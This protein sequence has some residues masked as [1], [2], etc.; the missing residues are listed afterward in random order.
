[1]TLATV[2]AMSRNSTVTER[3]IRICSLQGNCNPLKHPLCATVGPAAHGWREPKAVPHRVLYSYRF[4]T[5]YKGEPVNNDL[6]ESWTDQKGNVSKTYLY[7]TR[8]TTAWKTNLIYRFCCLD[9]GVH[10]IKPLSKEGFYSA[11][12]VLGPMPGSKAWS[13]NR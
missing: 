5:R 10:C 9:N 2:Q 12:L 3:G 1:M 6:A 13:R 4:T 11:F 7:R 8:L